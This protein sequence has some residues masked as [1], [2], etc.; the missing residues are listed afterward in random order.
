MRTKQIKSH[1]KKLAKE[2]NLEFEEKWFDYL[3]ISK[4]ENEIIKYLLGCPDPIYDRF[5]KTS[6][7]KIRNINLFLNSKEY[8]S[9]ISGEGG[10]VSTK[11]SLKYQKKLT[12]KI[13][14]KKINARLTKL[15]QKIESK[16]K[17]LDLV[18]IEDIAL[19]TK[20]TKDKEKITKRILRHEWIHI[21]LFKNKI[22]FKRINKELRHEWIHILL[23]K[24]KILFKR[25]NKE[26][27]MYDEGLVTFLEFFIDK[28]IKDLEKIEQ[29]IENPY[30]RNY[31]TYA[32]KFKKLMKNKD[33][34]Q[35][36]KGKIFELMKKL[37][38]K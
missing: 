22:L 17:S 30:R 7:E 16:L 8:K 12:K 26:Y 36:R 18:G 20:T 10:Q 33:T 9:M 23:F 2:F 13:K 29:K 5:G 25:I 21:L 35:V 37:Y 32:I 19:I 3:V 38:T 14:D 1:I 24:N 34:P 31:F 27:R 4:N 6:K 11:Y 28:N 15:N